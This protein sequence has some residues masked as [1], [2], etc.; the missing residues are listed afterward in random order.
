VA[1]DDARLLRE[2]SLVTDTYEGLIPELETTASMLQA[3][4]GESL[5][6]RFFLKLM[7]DAQESPSGVHAALAS[8]MRV[9]GPG[10]RRGVPV[11]MRRA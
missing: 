6:E 1:S 3:T 9:L 11:V 4:R 10:P 5:L 2:L 7:D 8:L